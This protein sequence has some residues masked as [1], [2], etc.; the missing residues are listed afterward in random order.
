MKIYLKLSPVGE[1]VIS[2]SIGSTTISRHFNLKNLDKVLH[3]FDNIEEIVFVKSNEPYVKQYEQRIQGYLG[4]KNI[5]FS[6][7]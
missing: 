3:E 2:Y 4:N 6:R 1:P 7:A 5:K